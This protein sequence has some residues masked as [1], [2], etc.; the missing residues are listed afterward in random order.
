[1]Q[2]KFG[3]CPCRGI[4]ASL[5]NPNEHLGEGLGWISPYPI[6]NILLMLGLQLIFMPFGTIS[7]FGR[8]IGCRPWFSSGPLVAAPFLPFGIC[9]FAV[10]SL[11][12]PWCLLFGACRSV[13][14]GTLVLVIW[15][16]PSGPHR[17]LGACHLVLPAPGGLPALVGLSAASGVLAG[18][19]GAGV[20]GCSAG[21]AVST[22]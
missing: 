22:S 20:L 3:V 6:N 10:W 18:A 15:C 16:L 12:G 21:M 2:G 8:I 9:C 7:Y 1:M 5:R 14:I 13:R 17:D 4:T 19:G 11:L